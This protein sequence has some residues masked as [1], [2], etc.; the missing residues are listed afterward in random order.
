M[1]ILTQVGNRDGWRCGILVTHLRIKAPCGVQAGFDGR[2]R[3]RPAPQ[4]AFFN[5]EVMRMNFQIRRCSNG[6]VQTR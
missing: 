6:A 2:S 4:N 1:F 3:P 5:L